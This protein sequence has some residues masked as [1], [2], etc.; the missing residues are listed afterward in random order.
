[1]PEPASIRPVPRNAAPTQTT[2]NRRFLVQEHGK[3][4]VL[5][6]GLLDA[7]HA[8]GLRRIETQI[9]QIPSPDNQQTAICFA[10]VETD[11]GTYT[12]LGDASPANTKP[13]MVQHLIRFAETR[14]KAR[15]L[16]DAINV[17]MVAFE[18]L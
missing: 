16:R 17:A 5:Y 10:L 4:F 9:I 8:Q 18:E 13:H 6:A 15:A 12:G 2:I 1:M 7:A 11:R 14:A 3:E